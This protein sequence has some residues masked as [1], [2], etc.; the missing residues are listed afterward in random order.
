MISVSQIN[1]L[2]LSYFFLVLFLI[3]SGISISAS[4]ISLGVA[5][6]FFIPAVLKNKKLTI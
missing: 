3:F 2:K 4:Q 1:F 6:L 5:I